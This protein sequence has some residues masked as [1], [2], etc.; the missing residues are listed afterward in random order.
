MCSYLQERAGKDQSFTYEVIIVDDGSKD[1]TKRVAF[2]F[3]RR[4]KVDNV[5]VV[6]LGKNQGRCLCGSIVKQGMLHSWGKLLLMLDADGATKVD[7]MEKLENQ[8]AFGIHGSSNLTPFV[9]YYF[10]A[11]DGL[12]NFNKA[13]LSMLQLTV[14][15]SSAAP[16]ADQQPFSESNNYSGVVPP[17]T[18]TV[19]IFIY[20]PYNINLDTLTTLQFNIAFSNKQMSRKGI[21]DVKPK[22]RPF[23]LEVHVAAKT[24]KRHEHEE[25]GT[26]L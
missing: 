20:I 2:D 11:L 5:R 10:S 9:S 22:H 13:W 4:Y 6:L 16:V 19:L 12:Q 23:P 15:V 21:A 7:D 14:L 24:P 18:P 26:F 1:G 8:V 17:I 25:L 3:V